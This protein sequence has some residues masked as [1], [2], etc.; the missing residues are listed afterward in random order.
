[1]NTLVVILV[2]SLL[3]L[4]LFC[5][6][7]YVLYYCFSL[8]LRRHER[9][10]FFLDLVDAGL[11]DGQSIEHTI[12]GVSRC[13]D[14]SLGRKFWALGALARQ[15]MTFNQALP[16][17]PRF[18]P[19]QVIGMLKAG[20][21]LGDLRKV[22]PACRAELKGAVDRVWTAHHYL[23]LLAFVVT[24]AWTFVFM[25]L[26]V[27]VFPRFQQIAADMGAGAP[28][29]F[30]MLVRYYQ[31][32]VI[33]QIGLMVVCYHA[34]F[35]YIGGPK[36]SGWIERYLPRVGEW[37][38]FGTPWRRKRMQ[39]NFSS[40]LATLL[41]SGVP[42][43][44]AVTLAAQG[45]AN[46]IFSRRAAAAADDLAGGLRLPEALGRLDDAGE[47]RWRLDNAAHGGGG[48]AAALNGWHE[49][50]EA[51]AYQQ[52]QTAAQLLTTGLVLIN[53]L[54]VGVL[55]AAVFQLLIHIMEVA[56]LW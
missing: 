2:G 45:A 11:K 40:L 49:S 54:F 13:D 5:G 52:E 6:L 20:M 17:I 50:L 7:G 47:L 15:G 43:P 53:G 23:M 29:Y 30:D 12:Q 26:A 48:F 33:F 56:P 31:P 44:H 55:A 18:L 36:V 25:V 22:L 9:A 10:R 37:V 32:L 28:S 16:L 3:A 39:R 42:E 41:D 21:E 27:F 24:P 34:A 8:P 51:K 19:D 46:R 35:L 38:A 4:P 14:R 1:M